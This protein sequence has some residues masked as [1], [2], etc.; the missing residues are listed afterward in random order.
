MQKITD[1]IPHDTDVSL[2]PFGATLVTQA[3]PRIALQDLGNRIF[4]SHVT[5]MNTII[6]LQATDTTGGTKLHSEVI[7]NSYTNYSYTST[8]TDLYNFM[9]LPFEV[10]HLI[11]KYSKNKEKII[12]H[13]F[14]TFYKGASFDEQE[15]KVIKYCKKILKIPCEPLIKS[16]NRA[17][18]L[19]REKL[20]F[21]PEYIDP[22]MRMY[23]TYSNSI[24]PPNIAFQRIELQKEENDFE[25]PKK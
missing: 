20:C 12:K 17:F 21:N 11:I 14:D 5:Y 9:K 4:Q 6:P 19:F 7:T 18:L 16:S 22:F 10:K 3:D 2:T 23:M 13:V 1:S 24:I 25:S 15:F 8:N